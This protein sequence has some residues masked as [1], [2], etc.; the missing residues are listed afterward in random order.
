MCVCV[1]VCVG[2]GRH[3]QAIPE[4]YLFKQQ[5][6]HC[7]YNVTLWR[8]RATI[9]V[10][11][12]AVLHILSVSVALGIRYGMHMRHISRLWPVRLYKIFRRYLINGKIFEKKK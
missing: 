11:E 9:V 10:V 8:V 1:C 7:T 6:R 2:G 4:T 12:K 3:I 5:D